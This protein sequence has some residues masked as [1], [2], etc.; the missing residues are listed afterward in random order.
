[1]QLPNEPTFKRAK[2]NGIDVI[3]VISMIAIMVLCVWI[4]G[5]PEK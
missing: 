3:V 1:M 4:G 2:F 5:V